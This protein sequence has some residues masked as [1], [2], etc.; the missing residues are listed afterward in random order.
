MTQLLWTAHVEIVTSRQLAGCSVTQDTFEGQQ[1]PDQSPA[2]RLHST[3]VG[4]KERTGF[5]QN[6]RHIWTADCPARFITDYQIR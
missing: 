3:T 1:H 2:E 6:T 4:P 5:M